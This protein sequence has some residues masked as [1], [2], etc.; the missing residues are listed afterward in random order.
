MSDRDE[1]VKKAMKTMGP[2]MDSEDKFIYACRIYDA[3]LAARAQQSGEGRDDEEPIAWL[4]FRSYRIAADDVIEGV[5]M[6]NKG[7]IGDDGMPA[8]PVYTHPPKAQGVPEGWKFERESGDRITIDADG[9]GFYVARMDAE[10]IADIMLYALAQDL[11]PSE[12]DMG[13]EK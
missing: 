2:M 10:R 11:L 6:C 7:E 4:K 8:Q 13:G 3:G 12:P 5:E 9:L 1:W